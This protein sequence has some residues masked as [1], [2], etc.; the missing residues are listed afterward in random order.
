MVELFDMG[1][2]SSDVAVLVLDLEGG[3]SS[4]DVLNDFGEVQGKRYRVALTM[5]QYGWGQAGRGGEWLG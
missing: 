5:S 4:R 1:V 3:G 2:A